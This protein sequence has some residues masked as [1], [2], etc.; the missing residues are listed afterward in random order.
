MY[1]YPVSDLSAPPSNS[2]FIDCGSGVWWEPINRQEAIDFVVFTPWLTSVAR[3]QAW[4][5]ER[6]ATLDEIVPADRR[7]VALTRLLI[8]GVKHMNEQYVSLPQLNKTNAPILQPQTL[9]EGGRNF[10]IW[11]EWSLNR[12][13]AG[14]LDFLTKCPT[15]P[16]TSSSERKQPFPCSVVRY[17]L[18]FHVPGMTG[19]QGK[20]LVRSRIKSGT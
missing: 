14:C 13:C 1:S 4:R 11:L 15:G 7:T 5:D 10:I 6:R 20:K 12:F 9:W 18:I 17:A 2:A 3:G 19:Q 8:F 16:K